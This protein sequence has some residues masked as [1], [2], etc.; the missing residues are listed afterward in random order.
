M[1]HR[2]IAILQMIADFCNQNGFSPSLREI[3]NT[4]NISSTSVVT[5]HLQKLVD[6]GLITRSGHTARTLQITDDGYDFIGSDDA[7]A[8]ANPWCV[9]E[10]KNDIPVRT[11]YC[12]T[13]IEAKHLY[14][15]LWDRGKEVSMMPL[16]FK[17]SE[18]D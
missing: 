9:V 17:E 6:N 14:N 11:W 3:S 4:V 1:N 2:S 7:V 15:T 13:H 8:E 16:S 5:Y 10:C 18:D 12:N